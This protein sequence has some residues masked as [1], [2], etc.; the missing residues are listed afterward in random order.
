MRKRPLRRISSRPIGDSLKE[1]VD[2]S[3]FES[4]GIV[5]QHRPTIDD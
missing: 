4:G 5:V 2:N 1:R 3:L